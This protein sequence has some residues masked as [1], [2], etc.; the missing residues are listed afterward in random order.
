MFHVKH[1]CL[2]RKEDAMFEGK[3]VVVTGA[4]RG[5]G[6]ALA[7]GFAAQGATVGVHYAHAEQ[8]ARAAQREIEKAGQRAVLL[9]A[10]L[11]QPEQIS[12]LVQEAYSALGPLDVWI[13]NA[14]ASANT[15]DTRGLSELAVFEQLM[16]VD[17]MGAWQ[18]SRQVEP[19]M[20]DGGCLLMMGWDGALTG[21][22]G[23]PAQLYAMSKGA[24][25]SLTRCLAIEFAPRL[26]VN[27]IAPGY[28][29]NTWF[30][31]LPATTQQR[32][33]HSIPMQRWG[34]PTDILGAALFL[35]S[36]A[37]VYITGQI[38]VVNGGK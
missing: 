8:G 25:I 37:A 17:V 18:C 24:I 23:L 1:C 13:N 14:G 22:A 34:T 4:G 33:A 21:M 38:L 9:Q 30:Q 15:R 28:V 3:S 6:R 16:R 19:L 5:I 36:P 11:T 20:R 27:C 29:E 12:R 35:A 32:I 31:Q 10:D 26:R 2:E 7:L